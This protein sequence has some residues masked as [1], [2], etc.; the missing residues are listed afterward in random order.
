MYKVES[1]LSQGIIPKTTTV[2]C[3]VCILIEF[4]WYR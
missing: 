2:H 3:W 1:I 4:S